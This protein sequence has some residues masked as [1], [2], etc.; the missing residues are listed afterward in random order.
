M[1]KAQ[2]KNKELI[3]EQLKKMP[4]VET[5][6]QKVGVS[7]ASYYRWKTEDPAFAKEADAAVTDGT[8]LINDAAESQLLTAIKD[9]NLTAIIFWLKNKHPD[10][11]QTMFQSGIAIGQDDQQN[12]YFEAFGKLKPET[13]RLIEPYLKLPLNKKTNEKDTK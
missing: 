3:L 9:G 1:K 13:E 11:K 8:K 7:R 10:Y 4:I 2:D 6:C 5:A 12:I